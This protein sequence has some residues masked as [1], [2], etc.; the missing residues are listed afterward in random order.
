MSQNQIDACKRKIKAL[1]TALENASPYRLLPGE[2]PKDI[3][4]LHRQL[5][6]AHQALGR[7]L[8]SNGSTDDP[9]LPEQI[10]NDWDRLL[11]ANHQFQVAREGHYHGIDGTD[12]DQAET[13]FRQALFGEKAVEIGSAP[14]GFTFETVATGPYQWAINR[15]RSK[16]S[17]YQDRLNEFQRRRR[18]TP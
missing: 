14:P 1:E 15:A 2:K 18:L 3:N 6:D 7:A 5:G 9:L 17:Q 16:K 4:D 8:M 11:E 13:Y 12:D 10:T